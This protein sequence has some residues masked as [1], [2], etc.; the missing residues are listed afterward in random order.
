MG[1]GN[2]GKAD[3]IQQMLDFILRQRVGF[4]QPSRVVEHE[5]TVGEP[6]HVGRRPV[7]GLSGLCVGDR[8]V[9]LCEEGWIAKRDVGNA[10]FLGALN[11]KRDWETAR[12]QRPFSTVSCKESPTTKRRAFLG[13]PSLVGGP[14]KAAI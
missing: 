1:S 9:I 3:H 6:G 14:G 5:C 13:V 2:V 12:R 7:G 11:R 8:F 10:E 4:E